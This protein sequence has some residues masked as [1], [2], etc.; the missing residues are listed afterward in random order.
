VAIAAA[1]SQGWL[2]V[3]PAGAIP[4]IRL[5]EVSLHEGESEAIA[6]AVEVTT[7]WT[8]LDEREARS[9]AQRLNLQITGVLG[10]L[11]R[12]RRQGQIP[13]LRSEM[14]RLRQEAHFFIAPELERHFLRLAGEGDSK[15]GSGPHFD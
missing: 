13:T 1:L 4:L 2:E 12:A 7:A 14:E 5:L 8:L 3:R 6:L 10:V 15:T 9:A 11:L